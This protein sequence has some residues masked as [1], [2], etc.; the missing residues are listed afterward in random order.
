MS[1][2]TTKRI[3]DGYLSGDHSTELLADNVIFTIMGTGE[4]HKGPEAVSGMLHYFYQVTFDARPEKVAITYGETNAVFEGNFVGKHIGE[5]NG[6]PA[7]GKEVHVPFCVSYQ[8]EDGKIKSARVY[9]ESA[10]M[11]AQLGVLQG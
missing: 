11:L 1:I 4:Q 9:M 2:E 7:T 3:V 10:V 5:F 6:I 8:V